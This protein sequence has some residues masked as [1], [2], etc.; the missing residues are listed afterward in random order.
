[1]NNNILYTFRRCPYAIRARWALLVARKSVVYREVS[2]R[3]KPKE[4]LEI[5]P[6]GTVPVLLTKNGKVIDESIEIMRWALAKN[7]KSNLLCVGDSKAQK[8]I[9][10]ILDRNDGDFKYHLDRY[11]YSE[12]FAICDKEFHKAIAR[13]I[14]LEWNERISLCPN[15]NWLLKGR[16]T[17][18]DLAVWPFVR[19]YRIA[20]PRSFD[21][22]NELSNLK[23][24]L[25]HYVHNIN[26]DR[27][28]LKL[29]PWS[30]KDTQTFSS[31]E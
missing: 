21:E 30:P 10:Y 16:E 14:L 1:M 20:D 29:K 12:R 7:D 8:E 23:K 26:F 28:M 19:Q 11:K 25:E 18:A 5:S 6:K 9:N 27:V 2:L 31:I 24:W 22:D 4:L 3:Q 15:N 17:L 13:E